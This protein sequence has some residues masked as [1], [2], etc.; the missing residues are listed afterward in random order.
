MEAAGA[1]GAVRS[2]FGPNPRGA[3]HGPR[4]TSV[5]T[6]G[7]SGEHPTAAG[8]LL[9]RLVVVIPTQKPDSFAPPR[10]QVRRRL[11]I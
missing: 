5:W 4:G 6:S 11:S 2:S 10:L 7:S 1:V 9:G 3:A 8:S